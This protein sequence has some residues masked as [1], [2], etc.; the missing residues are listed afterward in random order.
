[1]TEG[2]IH[3][4]FITI[5]NMSVLRNMVYKQSRFSIIRVLHNQGYLPWSLP[6]NPTSLH[7]C[8][9]STHFISYRQPPIT[10]DSN[11]LFSISFL[12]PYAMS[13]LSTG[14]A[15]GTQ[16]WVTNRIHNENVYDWR[17]ENK[18]IWKRKFKILL[19]IF[20]KETLNS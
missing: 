2:K 4:K 11:S 3:Q 19:L 6:P 10:P 9:S 15:L 8:V 18:C 13:S 5:L 14:T 1:M 12:L 20:S 7:K 17:L 16:Y